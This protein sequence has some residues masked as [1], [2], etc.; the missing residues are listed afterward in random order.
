MK[1]N[2]FRCQ[3]R[4]REHVEVPSDEP[5]ASERKLSK[6]SETNREHPRGSFR[7]DAGRSSFLQLCQLCKLYS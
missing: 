4:P 7:K 3:G 2:H 6:E 1:R 5:R